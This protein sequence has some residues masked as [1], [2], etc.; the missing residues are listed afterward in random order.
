MSENLIR[1]P[2]CGSYFPVD[3]SSYAEIVRQVRTAEFQKDIE[4]QERLIHD[5]FL[6]QQQASNAAMQ[7]KMQETIDSMKVQHQQEV[8]NI[9]MQAQA[10]IS[11]MR[12]ENLKLASQASMAEQQKQMEIQKAVVERDQMIAKQSSEIAQLRSLV[13]QEKL[14]ANENLNNT[15]RSYEAQLK[16]KEEA[17]A[18]YK[19]F[20]AKLSTKMVGENLEQWCY[21]E[22]NKVRQTAFPHASF[23]KDNTV[24]KSGSKGDFIFEDRDNGF[25]YIRI[26]FEM[27][28][29]AD[30]TEQSM[31]HKNE[32]FFRELDKDRNEKGCEF[33]VLV[34]TLEA[35]NEFYNSGIADVSFRYPKMYVV[36]P[37]CM[38]AIITILRDAARRTIEAQKH[39][40]M[41][42][43]QN[44][45]YTS[46]LDNL[47]VFKDSFQRN[48]TNAENRFNDAI[49]SIEKAINQ[50]QKTKEA[51]TVSSHHL[52]SAN[53]K[54]QGMTLKKLTANSPSIAEGF[55]EAERYRAAHPAP[56][57]AP[58]IDTDGY[59]ELDEED[60]NQ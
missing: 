19:D 25:P 35:D 60:W 51:L 6:S 30:T 3:D 26:M 36:R 31:R 54:V 27:K 33:A 53:K 11:K 48:C 47:A 14:M 20:R 44:I 34:S 2:H 24:S 58:L 7:Q 15:R 12:E 52:N 21:N 55:R 46:F 42:E 10:D 22:F 16:L 56:P 37:Q 59:N 17:I 32:S 8:A 39:A 9:S 40:R 49:T 13:E 5:K 18:Y 28:N 43:Q 4:Q 38:I 29:E 23:E 57:S 41:V 45:D 50:L 1:C